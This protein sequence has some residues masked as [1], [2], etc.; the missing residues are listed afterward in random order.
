M[1]ALILMIGIFTKL[2]EY[3]RFLH[4]HVMYGSNVDFGN[5]L[6]S[7]LVFTG[8]CNVFNYLVW[9][10]ALFG[11]CRSVCVRKSL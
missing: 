1:S 7:E 11:P 8:W 6:G 9:I 2:H 5:Y 3:C 10:R 4:L